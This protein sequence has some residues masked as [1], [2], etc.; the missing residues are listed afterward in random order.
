MTAVI[1]EER[2]KG[3]K[4]KFHPYLDIL[5]TEFSNMYLDTHFPPEHTQWIEKYRNWGYPIETEQSRFQAIM[6]LIYEAISVSTIAIL[7]N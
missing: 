2:L 3:S 1:V 7:Y 4:S 5:P 6:D